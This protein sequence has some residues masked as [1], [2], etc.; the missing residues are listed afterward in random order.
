MSSRKFK[1]RAIVTA[2]LKSRITVDELRRTLEGEKGTSMG[3]LRDVKSKYDIYRIQ[4][5]YGLER[6]FISLDN[7]G[8]DRNSEVED[9][10]PLIRNLRLISS[11][12]N[13]EESNYMAEAGR[14]AALVLSE[15]ATS[16]E[17]V[18]DVSQDIL[19]MLGSS[20]EDTRIAGAMALAVF[21]ERGIIFPKSREYLEYSAENDVNAVVRAEAR[22]ALNFY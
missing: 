22:R 12:Y 6:T 21:A 20:S 8:D 15:I 13:D 1:S 2:N 19:Q 9:M 14:Y 10:K 7:V 3:I 17:D 4:R 16:F 11:D 5:E 18:S